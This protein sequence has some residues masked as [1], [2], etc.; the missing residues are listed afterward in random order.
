MHLPDEG[1]LLRELNQEYQTLEAGKMRED[2]E[3]NKIS[4]GILTIIWKCYNVYQGGAK[5]IFPI[6]LWEKG[7]TS[8][9]SVA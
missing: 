4:I 9:I 6:N 8:G 3:K 7:Y 5:L 1:E 2:S